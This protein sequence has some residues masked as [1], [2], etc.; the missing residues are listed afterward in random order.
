MSGVRIAPTKDRAITMPARLFD[1]CSVMSMLI[2]MTNFRDQFYGK[3]NNNL[4]GPQTLGDLIRYYR[5]R[6][7]WSQQEL[8]DKLQPRVDQSRI[9]KWEKNEAQ[10]RKERL[11]GM[12]K[13][14]GIHAG[15]LM[16]AERF[17]HGAKVLGRM[18]RRYLDAYDD[19]ARLGDGKVLNLFVRI[20]TA[21]AALL[22]M[23]AEKRDQTT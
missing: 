2:R 4:P 1:S 19:V 17:T 12:A 8:G 5:E 16:D 21:L 15:E 7:G 11:I 18:D 14:F 20:V 23:V 9:S 6:K 10:P 22:K 13:L 3:D